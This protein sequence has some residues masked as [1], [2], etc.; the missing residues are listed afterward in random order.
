MG[1]GTQKEKYKRNIEAIKILKKCEDENRYAT[2]EE[3]E[4]LAQYVGWGGL[5]DA[6]NKTKDNWSE[7]YKELLS[8]L[9]E[10]EYEKARAST[11]TSFY[12]PPIVINAIY[13]ALEKMGLKQGNILEPSCRSWQLYGNVTR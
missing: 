11:L 5:A 3:Q 9:T 4:I 1:E 7:E 10:K 13:E 2:T 12:T 6:F 8:L